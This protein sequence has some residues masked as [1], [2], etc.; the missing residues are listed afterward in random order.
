MKKNLGILKL[1]K[2]AVKHSLWFSI[3]YSEVEDNWEI[4]L[5]GSGEGEY[6]RVKKIFGLISAIDYIVADAKEFYKSLAKK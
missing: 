4:I 5:Q 6:F 3:N 2:F 1:W